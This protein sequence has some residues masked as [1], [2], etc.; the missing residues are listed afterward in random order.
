[1]TGE[2][3]QL[4]ALA[5]LRESPSN[6]R[7]SYNEAA[8][9]E[10][11]DSIISQ[12]VMSPIIV[13]E[14][15]QLDVEHTHEIVFGHRRAR[16]ARR[17]GLQAIPAIVRDM[18][19]EQAA[20]AQIH[21]NLHRADVHPVEEAEAFAA[22]MEH[23]GVPVEKLVADS[24]K[25]RSY[26]YGR[27]KL[28]KMAPQVREACMEQGLGAETA[29]LLARLPHHKLQAEALAKIA[30]PGQGVPWKSY[31]VAKQWLEGY[32]VSLAQA[33]FDIHE[34]L[35]PG[36]ACTA[37]PKMA[38]NDP[39]LAHLSADICTDRGC[40]SSKVLDAKRG[41]ES[42]EAGSDGDDDTG[43]APAVNPYSASPEPVSTPSTAARAPV[44]MIGWT[45]AE[46]VT[47]DQAKW[48]SVCR[49]VIAQVLGA[50]R[51]G[52][53]LITLLE[54]ELGGGD[55]LGLAGEVAGLN[56]EFRALT[57]DVLADIERGGDRYWWQSRIRRMSPD[58][59][60]GLLVAIA[61]EGQLG[62]RLTASYYNAHALAQ[63]RVAVAMSWGIDPAALAGQEQMVDAGPAGGTHAT[64]EPFGKVDDLFPEHAA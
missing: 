38:G 8:L 39:D 45:P 7:R 5:D 37:C 12:G 9:H 46:Q 62:T 58:D 48:E 33:P 47:L 41:V 34:A 29:L 35:L 20:L 64:A 18:S 28:A 4:I 56:D 50:Q 10:L 60:A 24:G 31:R 30:D 17:A 13:R 2:Q 23:H 32:T 16:A 40:Y 15:A 22:L 49:L 54:R 52:A 14:L 57:P 11:A 44:E 53:D 1:M 25:S 51:T 21:E 6:P 59:A 55:D 19:D 61:V 26:I 36:G 27:L 42:G 43:S 3:T 63:E